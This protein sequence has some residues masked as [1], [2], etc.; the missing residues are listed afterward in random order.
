MVM[1]TAPD[2]ITQL[3]HDVEAGDRAAETRLIELV[4]QNLH[5]IAQRYMRR[6]RPDHTLQATALVHEAYMEL[7][8]RK[9]TWKDRAHFYAAAAQSIRRILVDHARGAR[10]EKRGG[11]ARKLTLNDL[12]LFSDRESEELLDIHNALDRLAEWDPRQAKIVELR[13]FGGLTETEIA[14]VLQVS[15]RTVK[16]DWKIARAWLQSQLTGA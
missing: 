5:R 3:L 7:R 9:T 2:S 15:E 12:L 14:E 8:G 16:E 6:E 4:Y 13:F 11:G 10:A 1:G